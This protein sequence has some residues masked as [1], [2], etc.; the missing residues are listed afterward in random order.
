MRE[1]TYKHNIIL[2]VAKGIAILL[3][4]LGHSFPSNIFNGKETIDIVAKWIFD[5]VYSFHMPVFFFVSGYL[6]FSSWNSKREG[7]IKKKACRLLIPYL[8]FSV[9]YI[10]LRMLASSMANSEFGNQYWKLFLGI[11]PNGGVWFLYVLFVF[12]MI[13]YYFISKRN[14]KTILVIT[15]IVSIISQLG[16]SWFQTLHDVAPRILDFFRFY[17]YFLIGLFLENCDISIND[18]IICEH[19]MFKAVIFFAMFVLDE[20]FSLNIFV[21]P[22]A[23]LGVDL[24]LIISEHIKSL[25]MLPWLGNTS[26]EIYL[27]HGPIMVVLRWL[28]IKMNLSKII[29]AIGMFVGALIISLIISKYIIH[30][31]WLIEFLCTGNIKKEK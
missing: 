18:K 25:Y 13:T 3:V 12:Y 16:I 27:L 28:L 20:M 1:S 9:L 26:M 2:D 30:K 31:I 7:T 11:S 17:C 8:A 24:T 23:V 6:F 4:V 10:P 5:L 14:I 22:I 21:V 19:G 29:I 15:I